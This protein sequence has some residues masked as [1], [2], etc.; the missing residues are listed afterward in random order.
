MKQKRKDKSD[1]PKVVETAW[2]T[3][4]RGSKWLMFMSDGS[5]RWIE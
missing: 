3:T 4:S 2:V 5:V 1:E